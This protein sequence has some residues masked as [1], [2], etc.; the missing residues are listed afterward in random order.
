MKRI[1]LANYEA[2]HFGYSVTGK[3]ASS[4]LS[5]SCNPARSPCTAVY[6]V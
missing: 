6:S 2:K 4:L 3:V 1:Q 5:A